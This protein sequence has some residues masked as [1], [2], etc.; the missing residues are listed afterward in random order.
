MT[1]YDSRYPQVVARPSPPGWTTSDVEVSTLC[2]CGERASFTMGR[3]RA[4]WVCSCGSGSISEGAD[5]NLR[6]RGLRWLSVSPAPSPGM[7]S[8]KSMH[9][10]AYLETVLETLRKMER[11]AL[12]LRD[13]QLLDAESAVRKLHLRTALRHYSAAAASHVLAGEAGA[14]ALET[15]RRINEAHV[16]GSYS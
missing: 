1:K 3:H 4:H 10:L 13:Q 7:M 2:L 5:G 8:S 6:H 12:S 16:A 15:A 14:R 11:D 9:S